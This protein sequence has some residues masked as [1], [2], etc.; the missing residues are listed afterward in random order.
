MNAAHQNINKSI[1]DSQS[2]LF[3]MNPTQIENNEGA[4]ILTVGVSNNID[5]DAYQNTL[6]NPNQQNNANSNIYFNSMAANQNYALTEMQQSLM[7]SKDH[8][9]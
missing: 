6:L 4:G 9:R 5:R 7:N 2:D 3:Q 1:H 8:K